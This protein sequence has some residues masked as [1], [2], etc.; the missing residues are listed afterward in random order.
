[1]FGELG[2][3]FEF[4]D[5]ED[6]GIKEIPSGILSSGVGYIIIPTEVDID[7]FIED[8][9]RTGR[10]SID[11]GFGHGQFHNV[12]IDRDALQRIKFPDDEGKHG[13][14]V[15]WVNIPK[16]NVPVI[17]G[18][19]DYKTKSCG[20]MEV[21]NLTDDFEADTLKIMSYYKDIEGKHKDQFL[22]PTDVL[23]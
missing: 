14:P 1:M 4:V 7:E 10:V 11:G 8:A 3:D 23:K 16:H 20:M 21:V 19:L 12:P 6:L 2:H 17:V 13:T 22:L 9:M 15:V 18:F 5:N